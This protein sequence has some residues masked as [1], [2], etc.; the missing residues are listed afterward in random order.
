MDEEFTIFY[1]DYNLIDSPPDSMTEKQ[2]ETFAYFRTIELFVKKAKI[3]KNQF[4]LDN[5]DIYYPT[6][7]KFS[8]TPKELG[9]I[10]VEIYGFTR[11]A[12]SLQEIA[13]NIYQKGN[14]NPEYLLLGFNADL[15]DFADGPQII[16][17]PNTISSFLK[18]ESYINI[19][20][21]KSEQLLP[22]LF[23]KMKPHFKE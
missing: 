22:K 7:L 3:S 17:L 12:I 5:G 15:V 10:E 8:G 2:D 23:E 21:N 11:R 14:E 9:D 6:T 16:K 20:L 19:L 4:I 18:D 13:Y 1:V